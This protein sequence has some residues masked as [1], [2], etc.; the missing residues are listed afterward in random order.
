MLLMRDAA[1]ALI[2]LMR[3]ATESGSGSACGPFYSIGHNFYNITLGGGV[4]PKCR[5]T[6]TDGKQWKVLAFP[7]LGG[8]SSTRGMLIQVERTQLCLKL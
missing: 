1:D 8:G 6:A 7:T 3:N 2:L 5:I 4:S